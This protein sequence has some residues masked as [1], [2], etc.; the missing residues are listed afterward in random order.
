MKRR[1]VVLGAAGFIGRRVIEDLAGDPTIL[2]VAAART[3][4][5]SAFPPGVEAIGL[6]ATDATALKHA[7]GGAAGLVNCVAGSP[8]TI[9]AN[10]QALSAALN[11]MDNPPRLVHLSSLAVYGTATG[12]VD[13][14]APL[15]GDLN[16]YSAA[17]VAAERALSVAKSLV[18]LRPGIVYGPGSPLWSDMIGRLL[19]AGR[20]GNLGEDGEGVCNLAYIQDLVLSIRHALNTPGIEGGVFNIATSCSPTW[21]EYFRLYAAALEAPP[22]RP[23]SKLRLLA[24]TRVLSPALKAAEILAGRAV[25]LPPAI[26]PWLLAHCRHRIRM[27][28]TQAERT[29]Q[30]TW[31]PAD[32]GLRTTAKWFRDEVRA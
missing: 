21:N 9:I 16:E 25:K 15:L 29:F 26:R 1:I 12:S 2:P 24:E 30:M 23:M 11:Q 3:V 22:V 28:V 17:K 4:R 5:G 8:S 19:A 10:A 27:D 14:S 18:I 6:D 32:S 20:L 7:I 13:E 31:L